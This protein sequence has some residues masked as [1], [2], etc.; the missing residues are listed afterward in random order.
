MR[1]VQNEPHNSSS[2]APSY[3]AQTATQSL[4][5]SQTSDVGIGRVHQDAQLATLS[6]NQC[7]GSGHVTVSAMTAMGFGTTPQH[8]PAHLS[9]FSNSDRAAPAW[10]PEPSETQ[11]AAD[12][13]FQQWFVPE[14][15]AP[16]GQEA[17]V[18]AHMAASSQS[19]VPTHMTSSSSAQ[20]GSPASTFTCL[21]D[22]CGQ[23][24][25]VHLPTLEEHLVIIHGYPEFRHGHALECRWTGCECKSTGCKGRPGRHGAHGGDIAR[26]IWEHHLSF[27][28]PCSKCGILGWARSWCRTRH[29]NTCKGRKPARCRTCGVL[30]TSE[31]ALGGHLELDRCM[32]IVTS[33]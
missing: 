17:Q 26:H 3:M 18:R 31:A 22:G 7:T 21:V 11:T 19:F 15:Q 4:Q 6:H 10:A 28:D 1:T 27:Q 33:P 16:Y 29:E 14:H 25:P 23:E 24:L 20:S 30:F 2:P 5:A 13:L 9:S 8:H 12:L 32:G